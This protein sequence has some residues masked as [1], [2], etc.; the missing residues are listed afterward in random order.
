[1]N[2]LSAPHSQ[3]LLCNS[4]AWSASVLIKIAPYLSAATNSRPSAYVNSLTHSFFSFNCQDPQAKKHCKLSCRTKA[5]GS[6]FDTDWLG[7]W[8]CHRNPP[9]KEVTQVCWL[10][11][12][13]LMLLRIGLDSSFLRENPYRSFIYSFIHLWTY[14]EHLLR[15]SQ[16]ARHRVTKN[17]KTRL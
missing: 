8:I 2:F 10:L 16:C 9:W 5:W 14:T 12:I 11:F 4:G 6:L 3:Q 13:Y 7:K 1:M 15:A 17:S